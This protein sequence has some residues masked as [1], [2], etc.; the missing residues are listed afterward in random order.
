MAYLRRVKW[1]ARVGA[2]EV[3]RALGEAMGGG[4]REGGGGARRVSA[5]GLMAEMGVRFQV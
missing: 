4:R 1:E 2:V 3:V 5:E